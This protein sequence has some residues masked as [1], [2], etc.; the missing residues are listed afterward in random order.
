[1]RATRVLGNTL[2]SWEEKLL[3]CRE[4]MRDKDIMVDVWNGVGWETVFTDLSSG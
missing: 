4:T 2:Q 3:I 1:V